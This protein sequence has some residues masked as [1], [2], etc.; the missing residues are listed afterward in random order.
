[1]YISENWPDLLEPGL[2]RV[3]ADEFFMLEQESMAPILFN[4][5]ESEKA[6]EHDLE[7]GDVADFTIF[8]GTV[9]YDD[10][11][12]GYKTDYTH[13]EFTRGLKVERKLVDDDLYSVINRRPEM[14]ALA[15][16][17]KRESDA[18]SVFNNSFNTGVT[19]GDSLPL[20][21]TAHTSKNGGSNQS[22]QG[23]TA[24][25]PTE[26]DTARIKMVKFQTNRNNP[27]NINPDMLI[28]PVDLESYAFEI[29]NSKGK[30]DTAQNNANFH[31]G[32]YKL[33]VWPNWLTSTTKWWLVDSRM[34]KKY[35]N[36]FDRIPLQFFKDS[37]FETLVAKYAGYMRYSFG[38]SE[39]RWVYGENA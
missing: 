4:M 24:L 1:M 39:W 12:E 19:G 26:V 10:T 9:A 3:M 20:C 36:W 29:I 30:V 18:A 17:R 25:S 22:N 13:N 5:Q 2:R 38:W 31:Y 14:L 32:R 37:D 27:T 28:V 16:Y 23:T 34:M 6:V 8:Q 7:I 11:G 35:L 21:S 33:V 15:A